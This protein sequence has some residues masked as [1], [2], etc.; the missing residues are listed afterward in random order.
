[1]LDGAG[2]Q[3]GQDVDKPA[4]ECGR[5]LREEVVEL[6]VGRVL[7]GILKARRKHGSGTATGVGY[8]RELEQVCWGQQPQLDG[9]GNKNALDSS[10]Q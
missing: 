10:T 9:Q 2:L 3:L 6:L 4:T 5:K 1:M 7:E 8:T